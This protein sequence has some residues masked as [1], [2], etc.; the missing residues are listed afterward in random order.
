MEGTEFFHGIG[1][2]FAIVSDENSEDIAG[3]DC[4]S[5]VPSL[6]C[7]TCV[8]LRAKGNRPNITG[9]IIDHV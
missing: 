7:D 9:E 3:L 1:N 4:D 2:E 8:G 5:L 6:E